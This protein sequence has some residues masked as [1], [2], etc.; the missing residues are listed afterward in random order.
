MSD[1]NAKKNSRAKKNK[2]CLVDNKFSEDLKDQGDEGKTMRMLYLRDPMITYA[3]KVN[4][5]SIQYYSDVGV[6]PFF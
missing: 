3:K 6:A 5:E 2:T 4:D 1:K